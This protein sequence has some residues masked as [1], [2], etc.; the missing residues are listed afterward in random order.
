MKFLKP[1]SVKVT[2]MALIWFSMWSAYKVEHFIDDPIME[3]LSP[4]LGRV[5]SHSA[6]AQDEAHL[7]KLGTRLLLAES[8][9]RGLVAYLCACTVIGIAKRRLIARAD[10]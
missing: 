4:E 2:V 7:A 9:S 10:V 8:F 6:T 5:V 1:T 3:P